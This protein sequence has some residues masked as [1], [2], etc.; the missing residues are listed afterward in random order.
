[1]SE[2]NMSKEVKFEYPK[3][4]SFNIGPRKEDVETYKKIARENLERSKEIQDDKASSI[5]PGKIQK[6][7]AK[8]RRPVSEVIGLGGVALLAAC[9]GAP[10]VVEVEEKE[11]EKPMVEAPSETIMEGTKK[12]TSPVKREEVE[13]VN[14]PEIPGLSFNQETKKYINEAGV[15]VGI[16]VK[17]ALEINGKMQPA[18]GLKPEIIRDVINENKEKGI[19]EF[20]WFFNPQENKGIKIVELISINGG[21]KYIGMKYTEPINLYAPSDC[22]YAYKFKYIPQEDDPSPYSSQ[23]FSG[24]YFSTGFEAKNRDGEVVPVDYEIETISWD[25]RAIFSFRSLGNSTLLRGE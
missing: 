18:I 2:T 24:I 7:I 9:K 11:E 21:Y 12:E 19:F 16:W 4:D 17:D 1:M 20:P 6:I 10:A 3:A 23:D 14:A 15:E 5:I 8:L 22:V 13:Q 25:I